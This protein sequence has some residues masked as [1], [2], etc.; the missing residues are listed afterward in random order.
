MI[1]ILVSS[2]FLGLEMI[3]MSH[4]MCIRYSEAEMTET[5]G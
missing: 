1:L 3:A 4:K 5:L 2:Y